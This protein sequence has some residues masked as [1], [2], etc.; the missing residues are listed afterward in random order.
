MFIFLRESTWGCFISQINPHEP[1]SMLQSVRD[2]D[3]T[4]VTPLPKSVVVL[5]AITVPLLASVF[6]VRTKNNK[7]RD[8]TVHGG[9]HTPLDV[10]AK[11]LLITS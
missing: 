4:R 1:G 10:C 5:F 6:P 2:L 11:N 3:R 8:G 7:T 9:D